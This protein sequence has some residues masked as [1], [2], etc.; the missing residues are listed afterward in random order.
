VDVTSTPFG[1]ALG[2]GRRPALV[3]IDMMRAY[4]TPGSPFDLG[5]RAAVDGCAALLTAA[6][7]AGVPVLHTRVR[8]SA[9]LSDGGL[10]VRKVPALAALAEGDL[11]EFVLPL[12][13]LPDEVVVV[14][15][16]ASAFFGTS[17]AATLTARGIDTTVIAGVSTSGCVRASATDAMQHGFRPIVVADACGD[18]TAAVHDANL[19]DLGAKY[20]DVTTVA[21]AVALLED[22]A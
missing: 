16:Y 11:G 4:F 20:A 3:L 7:S 5:S 19:F 14:K 9:D 22:F 2:W 18:R 15:Q 6:R 12:T 8:Y 1:G 21:E 17:L 10:F 13:P